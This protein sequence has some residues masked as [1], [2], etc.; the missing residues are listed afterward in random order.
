VKQLTELV[1]AGRGGALAIRG[2][3]GSGKTTLL[4]AAAEAA[5]VRVVEIILVDDAQWLDD[6]SLAVLACAGRRLDGTGAGLVIAGR[7]RRT[8]A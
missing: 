8:A 6:A 4:R 5:R 3:A 7:D 2:M 1:E